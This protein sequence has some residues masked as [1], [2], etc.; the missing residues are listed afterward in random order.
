MKGEVFLT[1]E[2]QLINVEEIGGTENHHR[3]ATVITAIDNNSLYQTLK[4]VH[5][6]LRTNRISAQPPT[7]SPQI[8]INYHSGFNKCPKIPCY[9]SL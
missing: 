4:L 2:F 9:T 5:R 8:F 3:N 7:L 1:E 6:A